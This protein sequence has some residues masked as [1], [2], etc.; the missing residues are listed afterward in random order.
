MD[1]NINKKF[2]KYKIP[3]SSKNDKMEDYCMPKKFTLQQQQLFLSDLLSSDLSPFNNKDIRGILI[4]H[5]IG[6][7]KTCTAISIAEKFKKK[8]ENNNS[9][10][11]IIKRKFF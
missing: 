5:Q 9:I 8:N 6:S 11:S 2:I 1:T 3:I 4:Y 7:G 10:T